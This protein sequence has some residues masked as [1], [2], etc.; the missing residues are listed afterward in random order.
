[1]SMYK[2]DAEINHI[3]RGYN[4]PVTIFVN[5]NGINS[6]VRNTYENHLAFSSSGML[7]THFL[8]PYR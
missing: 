6:N 5:V 8:N 3:I 2:I 7:L 4:D 1:M